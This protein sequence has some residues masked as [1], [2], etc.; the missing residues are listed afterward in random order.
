MLCWPAMTKRRLHRSRYNALPRTAGRVLSLAAAI[1]FGVSGCVSDDSA[2]MNLSYIRDSGA[3]QPVPTAYKP[4]I[5]AF[6]RAYLNEPRGI[7]DAG[8][9]EPFAWTIANRQRYVVCVRFD[10][11]DSLGRYQGAQ[12]NAALFLEGRVDRLLPDG[13]EICAKATYAAF[14][15]LEKLT[16]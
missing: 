15:E 9:S 1:G 12:A 8:V 11:R 10:A 13:P 16:R 4:E 5:L 14:P 7:R 2:S 6:L 3:V